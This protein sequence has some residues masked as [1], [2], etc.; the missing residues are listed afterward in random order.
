MNPISLSAFRGAS[1][2]CLVI[3]AVTGAQATTIPY[4]NDFSSTGLDSSSG[5]TLASGF[6]TVSVGTSGTSLGVSTSQFSNATNSSFTVSSQFRISSIGSTFSDQ[7]VGLVLFGLDA[8]ATGTAD[9]SRYILADWR[10]NGNNTGSLRLFEVD[11]S[12]T[13]LGTGTA[14]ANGATA[15]VVTA[16]STT[17]YTLRATITNTAAS[18][19]SISLGLFDEAGTT[20]IGSI[21]STS[22]YVVADATSGGYYFGVRSRLPSNTAGT[23]TIAFDSFSAIPEPSA[24]A[25][26]AG[27]GALGLAAT[28]R[29]RA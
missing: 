10:F 11:G 6:Q 14:D 3:F 28:R 29:R 8:G 15:G 1:F 9:T 2:S 24:F 17:L 13:V 16:S 22:D 27:L 7:A 20:Q 19:Y 26:L 23:T 12:N 25:V 4:E 21:A 5:F 18:T